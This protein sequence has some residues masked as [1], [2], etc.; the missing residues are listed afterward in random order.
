M[1]S[2]ASRFLAALVAGVVIACCACSPMQDSLRSELLTFEGRYDW[3]GQD[4]RFVLHDP[5]RLEQKVANRYKQNPKTLD[6][7]V[8]CMSDTTP[9]KLLLEGKPVPL[10]QVCYETLTMLIYFEPDAE[11]K[12]KTKLWR[13]YISAKAN[14]KEREEAQKEWR[15]VVQQHLYTNL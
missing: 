13:G 9:S 15:K 4:K 7:L 1:T 3:Y 10:G 5:A 14:D 12:N 2:A 11:S 8:D 6:E